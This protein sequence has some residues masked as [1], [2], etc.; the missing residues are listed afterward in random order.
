VNV[1]VNYVTNFSGISKDGT[2]DMIME[3][4]SPCMVPSDKNNS[5]SGIVSAT[6]ST[7]SAAQ[8]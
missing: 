3:R 7:I 5:R 6:V 1:D 4:Q 2:C 8:Y